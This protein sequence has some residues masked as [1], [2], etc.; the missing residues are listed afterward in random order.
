[1][2]K[3]I[4]LLILTERFCFDSNNFDLTCLS[5]NHVS[6]IVAVFTDVTVADLLELEGIAAVVRC[7]AEFPNMK[8]SG[9]R[10]D[11]S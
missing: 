9:L 10:I 2:I 7:K 4:L 5:K 6:L 1:M 8:S 11:K 3:T